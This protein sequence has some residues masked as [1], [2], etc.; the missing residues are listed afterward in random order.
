MEKH[1][2]AWLLGTI[3]IALAAALAAAYGMGAM[4]GTT[5]IFFRA[6]PCSL[7]NCT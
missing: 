4:A 6:L 5:L 2:V 7:T 1:L 3:W